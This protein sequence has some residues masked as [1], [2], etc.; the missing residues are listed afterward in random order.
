MISL[1]SI[2]MEAISTALSGLTTQSQRLADSAERIARL[3]GR[4]ETSQAP[5]RGADVNLA[6]EVVTQIEAKTAFRANVE[7]IRTADEMLGT[8]LDVT[9]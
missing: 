1:E 3:G 9:A 7:V 5:E 4:A 8:L 2:V 6:E